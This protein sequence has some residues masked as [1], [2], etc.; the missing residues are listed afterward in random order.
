MNDEQFLKEARK[1][2]EGAFEELLR[3][4]S[5][6]TGLEVRSITVQTTPGISAANTTYR[7]GLDVAIPD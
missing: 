2:I 4:F 6:S 1:I 3:E 5:I 7:V